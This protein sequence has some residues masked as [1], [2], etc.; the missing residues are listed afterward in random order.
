VYGLTPVVATA[1]SQSGP[2][3]DVGVTAGEGL[4]GGAA[5][6]ALTTLLLGAVL[7]AVFPAETERV[8]QAVLD[9]PFVSF[10]YGMVGLLAVAVVVFVLVLSILGILL[11]IPLVLAAYVGWGAGSAVAFLAV[12]D[13]LVGHEDGW[14][15]ALLLA[16]AT[17]GLLTL[18]GVGALAAF[19]IGAAGFGALLRPWLT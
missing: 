2:A 7:V 14:L 4:L 1:V 13:R 11:A 10:G 17:S 18:T 9:E 5:G 6:A 12:A 15:P 3:V 19:C 16:G 8:M